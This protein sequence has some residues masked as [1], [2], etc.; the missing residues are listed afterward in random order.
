[1]ESPKQQKI[2]LKRRKI[3]C[4]SS[5]LNKTTP[6]ENHIIPFTIRFLFEIFSV[7]LKSLEDISVGGV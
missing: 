5:D 7:G 4:G 1:M 2:R 6:D 3:T